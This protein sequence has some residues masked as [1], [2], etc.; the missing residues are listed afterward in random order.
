M[1]RLLLPTRRATSPSDAGPTATVR[2]R[3][4]VRA[5]PHRCSEACGRP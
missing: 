1:E 2:L 4:T 5:Q 3:P